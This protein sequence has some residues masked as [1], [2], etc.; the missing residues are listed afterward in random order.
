[1][2]IIEFQ[3]FHFMLTDRAFQRII[4]K[5][6]KNRCAPLMET[7]VNT[8]LFFGNGSVKF[9][10]NIPV[11]RINTAVADHFEMFFRDMPD[12]AL[13]KFQ[14]RNGFFHILVIFMTVIMESHI[15]SV[16]AVDAG[17]SNHRP[18]KVTAD[19]FRN[20][21]RITFVWFGIDIEALFVL[22]IA[23]DFL[24]FER[25]TYNSLHF[26]KKGSAKSVT[27]ESVIKMGNIT[28]ETVITVAAFRDKAVDM[29]IPFQIPAKGVK[30]HNKSRSKILGFIEFVKHTADHA[31]NRVE[32]AVK[33]IRIVQKKMSEVFINSKNAVPV[34]DRNELKGHTGSTFHRVFVPTGRTE[35]AVT[36]ERD[37]FHVPTVR[38][39]V[40]GTTKSGIAA[41]NHFIY[42]FYNRT[43][44]M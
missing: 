29:G 40:H 9:F 38:T 11:S 8:M 28:P 36:A 17:S 12:K 19:I 31:G 18:P 14:D 24:L 13:N 6:K 37:K 33:K 30:N 43:T 23:S 26:I 35:T 16:I 27:E 34:L 39:T 42:V 41:M 10:I 22:V 7:P 20:D 4:A 21:F 1:M 32:K 5:R 15:L 25:G 2:S 44:W 3:K